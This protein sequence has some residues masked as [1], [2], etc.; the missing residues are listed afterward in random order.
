MRASDLLNETKIG[1]LSAGNIVIFVDDHALEQAVKRN[2]L[3]SDV[4]RV[5]KQ[6]PAVENQIAQI[7]NGQKFWVFDPKLDVGLGMRKISDS[8]KVMLKT[9]VG[10]RPYDGQLP[11]ISLS[12]HTHES[13]E[14]VVEY[15]APQNSRWL[16]L[17]R[18]RNGMYTARILT[19]GGERSIQD[20]DLKRLEQTVQLKYGLELPAGYRIDEEPTSALR[21]AIQEFECGCDQE[22]DE[23]PAG[24]YFKG[25]RCTKDCSGH[26]AGYRWA[27]ARG[28][29]NDNECGNGIS[30]P[31]F[32]MGCSIRAN[33]K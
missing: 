2:I 13:V 18:D 10:S 33:E 7:D 17:G 4:D 32:W 1:E 5:I 23:A 3:P 26:L 24:L 8:L 25:S 22:L 6:F 15:G 14:P 21:Q 9:V 16:G 29:T 11:V 12:S 28:I 30:H 20:T 19:P 27:D 31:S